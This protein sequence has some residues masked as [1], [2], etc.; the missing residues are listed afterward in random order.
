MDNLDFPDGESD[1]PND[2][3]WIFAPFVRSRHPESDFSIEP[4]SRDLGLT[5]TQMCVL[6]DRLFYQIRL[7]IGFD[8]G[9]D[10]NGKTTGNPPSIKLQVFFQMFFVCEIDL[11]EMINEGLVRNYM[12]D[13]EELVA[14]RSLKAVIDDMINDRL[15]NPVGT[16]TPDTP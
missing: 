7:S 11:S 13:E 4:I 14:L 10:N 15:K 12:G 16:T 3:R 6:L 2:K 5:R 8:E 9:I 1:K